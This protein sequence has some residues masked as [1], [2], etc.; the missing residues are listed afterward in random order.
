MTQLLQRANACLLGL[1]TSCQ[2]P[3]TT[4]V[5]EDHPPSTKPLN[6]AYRALATAHLNHLCYTKLLAKK[7][8]SD[9]KEMRKNLSLIQSVLQHIREA[10]IMAV[11]NLIQIVA[12]D[13]QSLHP[14][15]H[16][17]YGPM[18]LELWE[19]LKVELLQETDMVSW[20]ERYQPLFL[21]TLVTY[22]TAIKAGLR[23]RLLWE[24]TSLG[25]RGVLQRLS[26]FFRYQAWLWDATHGTE[27]APMT[28]AILSALSDQLEENYERGVYTVYY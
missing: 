21:T 12:E 6:E 9:I 17:H 11:M 4:K 28:R 26:A 24:T 1:K 25:E 10:A 20:T 7:K 5:I 22:M 14:A 8:S 2:P 13:I 27:T 3:T 19:D 23:K 18:C 16:R 15:C